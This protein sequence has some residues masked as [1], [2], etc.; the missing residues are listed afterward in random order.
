MAQPQSKAKAPGIRPNDP[1]EFRPREEGSSIE[2]REAEARDKLEHASREARQAAEKVS[3]RARQQAERA[4][5]SAKH[6][7]AEQIRSFGSMAHA[8]ADR[9]E[10][11]NATPAPK[12]AHDL[13]ESMDDAA[14]YIE[15]ASLRDLADDARRFGRRHPA[16]LIGGLALLGFAAG[17]VLTA[18][19][20]RD[21]DSDYDSDDDSDGISERGRRPLPASARA[22]LASPGAGSTPKPA[23]RPT[24]ASSR[25]VNPA[26]R[27][28]VGSRPG[29]THS[30][31]TQH[32]QPSGQSSGQ[33]TQRSKP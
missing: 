5:E 7:I 8:A 11:E 6:Q 17:R 23:G 22:S 32:G 2:D 28:A 10:D 27:P 16:L 29:Q 26:A 1:D 20:E 3:N 13:A 21:L 30:Q 12:Y 25:A 4:G 15:N 18:R 31:P 9:G 14:S 19:P 24:A 33:S